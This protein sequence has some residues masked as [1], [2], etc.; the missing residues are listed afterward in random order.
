MDLSLELNGGTNLNLELN[1]S[2]HNLNLTPIPSKIKVVAVKINTTA[3]WDSLPRFIP[4]RGEFI[5]YSDYTQSQSGQDIPA[6]KIGDG[7]S[8]LIDMPF[9]GGISSDLI[10]QINSHIQNGSIHVTSAEKEF[11]NSKVSCNLNGENLI[12]TTE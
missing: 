10:E 12:F 11:W 2:S 7:R 4:T 1:T 8:F 3:Y 6:L 9:I 5:V